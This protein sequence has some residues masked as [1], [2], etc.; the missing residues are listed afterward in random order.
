[1]YRFYNYLITLFLRIINKLGIKGYPLYRFYNLNHLLQ[2][3][4]KERFKFIQVGANDGISFDTLYNFV[5]KRQSSGIVIEPVKQYFQELKDNY[6]NYPAIK[7]VNKGIHPSAK[8]VKI[9]KIKEDCKH[10]YPEWVRGIASLDPN[11]HKKTKIAAEHIDVENVAVDTLTNIIRENYEKK[12]VDYLQIDTEGFDLEVLKLIDFTI[13]KPA[14]IQYEYIN[15]KK[16]D[17]HLAKN[18]LLNKG[19]YLF[20]EGYNTIGV[21]LSRVRIV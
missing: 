20:D 19:Y 14:I 3:N 6:K 5:I 7:P 15:L 1:M 12:N 13:I 18:L 2:L 10:L 17:I 4:F 9:Y 11:H 21:D 16:E 8:Q